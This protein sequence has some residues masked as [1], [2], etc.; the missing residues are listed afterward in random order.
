MDVVSKSTNRLLWDILGGLLLTV[1]VTAVIKVWPLLFPTVA[2][3]VV[4]DSACD[5]HA[6][7][8]VT[9][10]MPAG[11]ISFSIEPR[12]IPVMKPLR[13]RVEVTEIDSRSVE[14]DFSGVDMNM[15]FNRVALERAG[16]GVYVGKAMLPVC[17]RDA[18]EWEANIMINTPRGLTSVVYRF[19]TVRPGMGG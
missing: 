11:R 19:V 9:K 4:A 15:G 6:G 17:I 14:I 12:E 13:L 7:P 1:F 2:T 18:M 8:C 16:A 3:H 10:M 5:L